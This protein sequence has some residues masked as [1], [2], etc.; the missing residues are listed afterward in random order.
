[1]TTQYQK[2]QATDSIN[3]FSQQFC[4]QVY[5]C[6]LDASSDTTLDVP[7]GGIM[8]NIPGVANNKYVAV[9]RTT[10]NK[11]VWVALNASAAVPGGDSFALSTSELSSTGDALGKSCETGDVL[12]FYTT[13]S[14][15][16]I[17]VAF[18]AV[19]S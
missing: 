3:D 4:D 17:S 13:A 16:N 10:A 11:D 6:T 8:G 14:D 5:T 1:M 7:G 19:A 18:Y 2:L 12:H 15:V 9:I